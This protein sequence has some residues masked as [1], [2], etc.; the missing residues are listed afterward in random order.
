MEYT[1]ENEEMDRKGERAK[2][3]T[4]KE[5]QLCDCY[6]RRQRAVDVNLIRAQQKQ[7]VVLTGNVQTHPPT[8]MQK[9][10]Q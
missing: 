7:I 3:S 10:R 2:G 8:F 5:E 4:K 6:L 9:S 1:Q